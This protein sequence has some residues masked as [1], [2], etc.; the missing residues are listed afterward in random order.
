MHFR[1]AIGLS[2]LSWVALVALPAAGAHAA[3]S[4]TSILP[5]AGNTAGGTPVTIAG[6]GFL[7]GAT[8]KI[9]GVACTQVKVLGTTGV[10]AV[11][12]ANGAGVKRVSVFNPTAGDSSGMNDLYTY[13]STTD[14]T[15]T[16]KSDFE[17]SGATLT[18]LNTVALD[19]TLHWTDWSPTTGGNMSAATYYYVV[20]ATNANGETRKSAQSAGTA[21]SGGNNAITLNWTAIPGAFQYKLYRSTTSGTYSSPCLIATLDTTGYKDTSASP[22]TGA[23][24]ASNTASGDMFLA[25]GTAPATTFTAG[26]AT[27]GNAG[28]DAFSIQ[29]PNGTFLIVHA[30]VATTTSIYDPTPNTMSAGPAL[31]ANAGLGAHGLKRPDGTFLIVHGNTSTSTSIYDPVANTMSAGPTLSANAGAGAHAI[32]RPDGTFLI[33]LG[34]NS[35]SSSNYDPVANTTSAGPNLAN[36]AGTGA[37]AIPRPDG[38]VLIVCGQKSTATIVYDPSA[39]TSSAGPNI[40]GTTSG[41]GAHSIQRPDGKYLI[42]EGEK[43]SGTSIYNPVANSMTAGP[44]L[45]NPVHNGAHS[46]MRADGTFLIF[47]GQQTPAGTVVYDPV[48]NTVANGPTLANNVG[49]GGHSLQLPDGKY[50]LVYGNTTTNTA[51][52]DAGWY[53]T[54]SYVS[55]NIHPSDINWWNTISWVRY[56]DDTLTVKIKTAGSSGGLA[57]ASWRDV[58][59][60]AG[61]NPGAGESWLQIGADHARAIPKSSLPLEDVWMRSRAEFRTWPTPDILSFTANYT[62]T[63]LSVSPSKTTFAFGGQPLNTW[64]AADSSTV[65]NDGSIAETLYGKIS[66]FTSGGYTWSLSASS[67]GADQV[68]AQWST[69]SAAGP[70]NDITAYDNDFL[71]RTS[72]AASASI[73]FYFRM[74][75]PTSTSALTQYASTLT[76]TAQ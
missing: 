60:G 11:T 32:E 20:T 47:C 24:P 8:V 39:N 58:T 59:N 69:T 4:V 15:K 3:P 14:F 25:Y 1:R 61:I 43:G 21:L 67:N 35:T 23:P 29:R 52:Y 6:T 54:G 34:G 41:G 19:S 36:T 37:H 63:T 28:G 46:I 75:T 66:T 31:S 62:P 33:V 65:T 38:K 17:T 45:P 30:G 73:K 9:G 51:I 68:R 44:T 76:V 22:S 10:V 12:G 53:R 16:I 5:S 26:P 27:T 57:S 13:N 70:W 49:S 55:E 40:N 18:R 48:A 50:L 7:P 64:L 56:V 2:L 42:V 72:L 74:Q 71:I